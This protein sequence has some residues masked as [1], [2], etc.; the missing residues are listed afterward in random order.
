MFNTVLETNMPKFVQAVYTGNPG[1]L[2][3]LRIQS[4]Q[5]CGLFPNAKL[6][7]YFIVIFRNRTLKTFSKLGK[8]PIKL[9]FSS[10]VYL[11]IAIAMII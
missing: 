7:Y 5:M 8:G 9:L 3:S 1:I 6:L 2:W 11:P 4:C 10:F